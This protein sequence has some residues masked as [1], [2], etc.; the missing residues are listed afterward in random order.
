MTEAAR[1][2]HRTNALTHRA[3]KSTKHRLMPSLHDANDAQTTHVQHG[4]NVQGMVI[5]P[6]HNQISSM[7]SCCTNVHMQ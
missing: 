2:P 7:P 5:M 1:H 4:A 3:M 6:D